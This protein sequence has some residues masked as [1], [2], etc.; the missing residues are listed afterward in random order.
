MEVRLAAVMAVAEAMAVMEVMAEDMIPVEPEISVVISGV[1]TRCVN[2]WEAIFV[3]ACRADKKNSRSGNV[4]RTFCSASGSR[5]F[6]DGKYAV[7]TA[8]AA[9]LVGY[10]IFRY[11]LPAGLMQSVICTAVRCLF[12]SG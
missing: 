6:C 11:G 7:L 2:V 10:A 12:K 4:I 3:H 1:P 9:Y 5:K 8:L